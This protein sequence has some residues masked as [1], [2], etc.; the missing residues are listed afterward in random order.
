[1]LFHI[2]SRALGEQYRDII[3]TEIDLKIFLSKTSG[4]I[5][6]TFG[7]NVP[8]VHNF[9]IVYDYSANSLTYTLQK[10]KRN[11]WKNLIYFKFSTS[12]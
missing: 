10:K 7:S 12:F 9:K 6:G 11:M 3:L 8:R 5:L 1:M 4:L 2:E